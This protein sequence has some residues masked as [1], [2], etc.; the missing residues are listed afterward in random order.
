MQRALAALAVGRTTLVI[1]HRLA[2]IRNA[3]RIVVVDASGVAEQ[4]S[5]W[6]SCWR[7][8][9]P[10]SGCTPRSMAWC[11]RPMDLT[12]R[13]AALAA[14]HRSPAW[15]DRAWRP[16]ATR[17]A[18]CATPAASRT[19]GA[20]AGG[21]AGHPAAPGAGHR[22]RPVQI[23]RGLL[24][25]DHRPQQ[26][27]GAAPPDGAAG[28]GGRAVGHVVDEQPGRQRGPGA[29]HLRLHPL[30]ADEG[31][32]ARPWLGGL[33][34]Q[35]AVPGRRRPQRGTRRRISCSTRPRPWSRAR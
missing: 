14:R 1:A 34:R 12:R 2:T 29:R 5:P 6:G 7:P 30:P 4:G 31:P 10:I 19:A 20:A 28:G 26:H 27:A 3:D 21:A 16:G 33:G 35:R 23:L 18:G 17:A 22:A 25:A 32:H 9:A 8:A 13:A 15:R 11:D 24:R